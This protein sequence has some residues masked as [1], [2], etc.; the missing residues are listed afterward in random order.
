[1]PHV[2]ANKSTIVRS[3]SVDT[4]H[5]R[6]PLALLQRLS[7]G[8]AAWA[9]EPLFLSPQ[10]HERPATEQ[11]A[12]RSAE[13]TSLWY[14]GRQLPLYSWGE[15][16]IVLFAHGWE[17]RGTQVAPLLVPLTS[18]GFRVVAYDV[19]GHGEAGRGLV[20]VVDFGEVALAV[21]RGLGTRLHA[22]VGHSVGGTALTMA[23]AREPF[24][25]RLVVLGSPLHPRGF[26]AGFSQLLALDDHTHAALVRRL[27]A[28]YQLPFEQ[29]HAG[30]SA[31]LVQAEVL[32]VHD[33]EDRDV[34]FA[35]GEELA[36]SFARAT[37][38]PT[39]GLGHRRV[40]RDPGVI[41]S[42][43]GFLGQPTRAERLDQ[44]L[45][46]ELFERETR[47]AG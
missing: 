45:N 37:L 43:A 3:K 25:E 22:A 21:A 35:H 17:G 38:L 12:F 42:I 15:G 10:R 33:R 4:K 40:L 27:E 39:E 23:L 11:A 36:R 9:V 5:L 31:A 32:V 19:P 14:R 6:G 26:L 18:A 41:A 7:P 20:S 24:S 44:L 46:R 8:L 2:P 16:P 34:P 1:M 28:R 13:R 47:L 29:L 30:E